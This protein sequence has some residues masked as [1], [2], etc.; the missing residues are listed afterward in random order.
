MQRS[1]TE[2]SSF[3]GSLYTLLLRT[4][5]VLHTTLSLST[6]PILYF[7]FSTLYTSLLHLPSLGSLAPDFS[8]SPPLAVD[9]PYASP[10]GCGMP[11]PFPRGLISTHFFF[12]QSAPEFRA[13]NPSFIALNNIPGLILLFTKIA[14]IA[15]ILPT[16]SGLEL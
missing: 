11:N 5:I 13:P 7:V 8:R 3:P 9:F 2:R 10:S 14:Q 16:E 6:F 12:L 15:Y 4:S 1:R